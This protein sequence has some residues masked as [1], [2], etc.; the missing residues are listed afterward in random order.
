MLCPF[1]NINCDWPGGG[2]GVKYKYG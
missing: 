2:Q 1:D